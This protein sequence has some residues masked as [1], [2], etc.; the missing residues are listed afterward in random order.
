[1]DTD[2]D[3]PTLA[4]N[5]FHKA[6]YSV[7]EAQLGQATVHLDSLDPSGKPTDMWFPLEAVG[8]MKAA[9]GEVHL[10][11]SFNRK[12]TSFDLD[13]EEKGG[14]GDGLLSA[15]DVEEEPP[16]ELHVTVIQAKKLMAMDHSLFGGA[17]SSDPQVKIKIDGFET[18]KSKY[19]RKNLNPTWN[20]KFVWAHVMDSSLS[21]SVTVEDHNDIKP[22]AD[23]IGRVA[24][25]LNEYDSKKP[26]RKWYKLLN[27]DMV[28]DGTE[29]GE[30][31][32]LVHWKF[33][34]KVKEEALKRQ[35]EFENSAMGKLTGAMGSLSKAFK[36]DE[37]SNDDMDEDENEK[38]VD[39]ERPV[40]KTEEEK[41]AEKKKEDEKK[42]ELSDIEIKDGDYQ[43]QVHIIECR[44]LKA[45]NADGTSDP[46]VF[47]ECF[48]QKRNTIVIKQCTSCVFDELFIFNMKNIDKEAFEEG[49]IR[50]SCFDSTI[51][52]M[53][54]G[55]N[56]MIGSYAIDATMVYTMNKDH[57]LY[58]Q[59]VPL[60]DD[61]DP[62]DVGVQGYMKIS[63]SIVGPGEKVKVHDEDAERA[64][65]IAR[66]AAAGSDI[67]SLLLTTPTIQKEWKYIVVKVFK[68]EGLPVMD[69]KI[70]GGLATVKQAGTDAFCRLAF[71]GGKPLATRV[72]TVNGQ[73]RQQ[74]N[75][76]F[77][78][79]LWYP[80]SVPTMT[81]LIK[82]TVWDKDNTGS[83]LIGII[84]EKFNA[85]KKAPLQQMDLMWYNM[86]GAPE[87]KQEKLTANL[88]KGF[89]A[90]AN[91]AKQ[92]LGAEIDWAEYYNNSPEKASCFKGRVL[93]QFSIADKR[94]QKYDKP[95]VKPFR[96]RIKAL[97]ST[98]EP[99]SR[100]YLLQAIVVC[101]N[102]LPVLNLLSK[103]QFRVRVSIG[104]HDLSTKPVTLEG[105]M[106]RWNEFLISEKLNLPVDISRIPDIF[107]YLI[108]DDMKPICYARMK[109]TAIYPDDPKKPVLLGFNAG[110]KW[111]LMQEDKTIDAL[112]KDVFP[113]QVLVKL[114]FGTVQ[115]AEKTRNEWNECLNDVKRGSQYQVRVHLYQARNL[116]AAD[117][118]GLCDPYFKMSFMGKEEKSSLK[119]KTL[120][121]VYYE[122]KIFD[123]VQIPDC[124]TNNFQYASQVCF[125]LYDKD[126]LDSDDYLGTCTFN[127]QE[128]AVTANPDDPLPRPKWK[129]LFFEVPGDSQGEV[130]VMVQLIKTNNAKV[131]TVVQPIRP[132]TVPAF[133]EFIVIGVR[134]MSPYNFQA[135]QAP[136]LDIELSSFDTKY[137]SA[138]QTS[139]KPDPSNPNFLERI[140]IPVELPVDSIFCTPLCIQA[141][142]TRLGGYLKPVVGVCQIDL[143]TKLPWCADTYIAP[144]R[145]F[146]VQSLDDMG[147]KA[148][149]PDMAILPNANNDEIARKTI[150]LQNE[151]QAELH[152]DDFIVSQEPASVDQYIQERVANDD[153]GAGVFGALNHIDFKGSNR[154]KKSMGEAFAD[155]DWNEDDGDQPPSWKVNRKVLDAELELELKTTPF[156]TYSLTRG[157]VNGFLGSKVKVVGRLKGLVRVIRDKIEIDSDPLL[158]AKL[159]EQLLKPKKYVVRL[160]ALRAFG[161]EEMDF[162]MFGN[163]AKSDPYIRVKLGKKIF[164]DRQNALQDTLEADLYKT[165]EFETEL[166]GVSQLNVEIMDQDIIGSDDLIGKTGIDLEDRWF[167]SRWQEMGQENMLLPGEDLT[168]P[169]KVRWRT[170]PVERRSLYAPGFTI[171]RGKN[172]F[173]FADLFDL[174]LM[175]FGLIA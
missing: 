118:N 30:I 61:E 6:A 25:S 44:D 31:E 135:M 164:D 55:K 48:G 80:V 120:F 158:P 78:Y 38:E 85:I 97:K 107:V 9:S 52:S 28:A 108:R 94:P 119:R 100:E 17:G 166:P 10:K 146:F 132:P 105:G 106:C 125:R 155:P 170:K 58:R 130:L 102:E 111:I 53:I 109:P 12:P 139:K 43:I 148:S 114:G 152:D 2:G 124:G 98:Q 137:S 13:D 27:K 65:E 51:M 66:E 18:K 82:F 90:V 115:D 173:M 172:F 56:K 131:S 22:V 1:M 165:I 23:F 159:M 71:A 4:V 112:N 72:V 129:K 95:E 19:I 142:D 63:I 36:N 7:S 20:E 145:E 67:G 32:L 93:L 35:K 74:I 143:S 147:S 79:E 104:M 37:D 8:R 150:M 26:I 96:R 157:Q 40:E 168:D 101:G 163:K 3:L 89:T 161:L 84:G 33:N 160:Y 92:S 171:S 60:I 156:E 144:Q 126:D 75:P 42:K 122:T 153:T 174:L 64:A 167:D 54:G 16:N 47:V 113:G 5:I 117:S 141:K 88:K 68:A 39:Q 134:D 15:E 151:R 77:N 149:H 21:L 87:F 76:Q 69:G 136:F 175:S 169:S 123:G 57:E 110:A 29:R 103:Q 59:W 70:G 11:L 140:V 34:V 50:I 86:Y 99:A 133:I 116:P 62:E 49:M 121:P 162:D 14:E 24:I 154:K 41:E 81:Q 127:L 138:T 83:E 46:I 91:K 45:E 128:A 73:S